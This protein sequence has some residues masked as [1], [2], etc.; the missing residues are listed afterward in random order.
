MMQHLSTMSF[1]DASKIPD[2]LTYLNGLR[3]LQDEGLK[4]LL[5]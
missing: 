3:V 1:F 5:A 2:Q 4:G